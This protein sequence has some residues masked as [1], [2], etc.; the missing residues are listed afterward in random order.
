MVTVRR[1]QAADVADVLAFLD[2]HWKPGHVFTA[3]RS[4]FD[5]Q[6]ALRDRPGEYSVVIARRDAD[7]ALVGILGYIPTRNFDPL[8]ASDNTIWLALWKVRDDVET[9]GLGLRL[10]KYVTD[11]EPHTTIGVIGFNP[12]IRPIY[13]ALGFQIGELQHF[14]LPNPDVDRFGL[15]L[16]DRPL[17]RPVVDRGVEAVPVDAVSFAQLFAGLD[18][19]TRDRHAPRKTAAYFAAR[20]LQHPIYRYACFVLRRPGGPIGLVATRVATHIGRRAL[21]IVDYVGPPDAV[22]AVGWPILGQIRA[23]GAEYADVYNWGIE[24][25]L[26]EAA[27]FSHVDP[28]GP[29]IVPDHFE[30]FEQRNVRILF[31]LKT[32]RPAVLFKGD[33]DQDRPN[34]IPVS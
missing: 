26:F 6:H 13:R 16:F 28:D 22:P 34:R 15:A 3:E 5:W 23:L 27:G 31:A 14:V 9:A 7:D 4:L 10:V 19:G 30:P 21:R 11:M 18:L 29:A 1:C 24:P 8:L 12:E 2:A 20:Y 17:L 25:E 32:D 33:A